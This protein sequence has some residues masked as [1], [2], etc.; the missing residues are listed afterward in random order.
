MRMIPKFAAFGAALVLGATVA[1]AVAAD[2]MSKM[3][4]PMGNAPL[5]VP[6]K[7]QNASG[8]SGTATLTDTPAGLKVVISLKGA[9]AGPQPAHIHM[10]SCAHLNPTPKY[11]L[12]MVV[13]GKSTT[14]VKGITISQLLGK[15]AINVHKSPTDIA[16]YV[17]CG[18][19]AKSAMAP[20]KM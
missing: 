11:P 7:P 5:T 20:M 19:I 14:V 8:E 18:D 9:P 2:S 10:G 12:S 15:T 13:A 4:M 1:P 3:A 6:L 17:A 16:T